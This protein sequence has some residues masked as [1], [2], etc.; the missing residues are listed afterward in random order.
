MVPV[1]VTTAKALE[2]NLRRALAQVDALKVIQ[3]PSVWIA[4]VDEHPEQL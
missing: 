4:M 2:G 1:V 3:P